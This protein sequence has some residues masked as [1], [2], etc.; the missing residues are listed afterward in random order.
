[1]K[2]SMKSIPLY[3]VFFISIAPATIIQVPQDQ[4][5]IQLG[6]DTAVHGDTV[7]V[8]TGTYVENI[9]FNGKNIL[10]GSLFLM[11]GD[12]SYISQTV[13]DGN[14]ITMVV[15]FESGEGSS[16]VLTGFTITNGGPG[17]AAGGIY[18]EASNP[19]I[20]NC[21]I[22]GNNAPDGGGIACVFNSNPTIINCTISGNSASAG[23]GIHCFDGSNP[24]IIN[25]ILWN[26][27]PQEIYFS[28]DSNPNTITIAYSN[29]QGGEASI[30]TNNNG[31][32]NWLEGN[33]DVD[34][35]F[36]DPE[37]GDFHLQEGSSCIDAGTQFFVW[38]GDILI[39]LSPHDYVGFARDM[40]A[41]EAPA[42]VI[43]PELSIFPT[44]G[45][46]LVLHEENPEA[47]VMFAIYNNGED[48]VSYNL[49]VES[50][51]STYILYT[52]E[53]DTTTFNGNIWM[54]R[55]DGTEKTQLTFEMLDRESVWSPD[56]EKI[57]FWS[58]RSGNADVWVMNADGSN[59]INLTDSEFG[60]W[61]PS[62]SSDG[63][64]IIFSSNRDVTVPEIYRMTSTGQD[65]QRLTFND[66]DDFRP[67]YSPNGQ[68]FVTHSRIPG[69][70]S[71][72]YVYMS[73]GQSFIN[74]GIPGLND[75]QPSWTPDGMRVVWSGILY[76]VNR[77][78]VSSL[79]DGSDLRLEYGT[80]QK[81]YYPRFSPDGYFLAF[82][83]STF[84][85]YGGDEIFVW[86]KSMNRLTQITDNTPV[87]REW[88]P[89]WSPFLNSP[90]WIT[91]DVDSSQISPGGSHSIT[92][93]INAS[94]VP[95]GEHT[96]SVMIIEATTGNL[97][98]AV[99]VNIR[100]TDT[101]GAEITEIVDV[102]D[103]QGGFVHIHFLRSFYDTD[104]LSRSQDTEFY[105]LWRRLED[106]S[107]EGLRSIGAYGQHRY[108]ILGE[109]FQDATDSFYQET[110]FRITAH[111]NEGNFD[112]ESAWG[113]S[114]DNIAPGIPGG[115]N[116]TTGMDFIEIS[117]E[118]SSDDDF[119]FFRI[120]R[121]MDPDFD[122]TE[123]ELMSETV[124][125]F[126]AEYGIESGEYFYVV[127]AVDYH[128]NESGFSEVVEATVS[129]VDGSQLPEEYSL[130][131]N[132]PNPF[133]PVTT[134]RYD[135]PERAEVVLTVYDILGREVKT[136]VRSVQEPGFKSV[137]WN[138]TND[139]G[140]PMSAGIYLYRIS[141]GSFGQ[142]GDFVQVKKM[143]LLK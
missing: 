115:F 6:I 37:N 41:F 40:G 114:W 9:N 52:D 73:D 132:Y 95:L 84:Y 36:V 8:D 85:P 33:I 57:V 123:A 48:T 49:H 11:T 63:E 28:D 143:V 50:S 60:E 81:E 91:V 66:W 22:I 12:T 46:T 105:T 39:N 38:E 20:T 4:P 82:P 43:G 65:I 103:D 74:I 15:T 62:W 59:P 94:N 133:N 2:N 32:I 29:V 18:C 26:N 117:W 86:H 35:L 124:E 111:M 76:G 141:A 23:G 79:W 58:Y 128:W 139:A 113:V 122:P 10:L 51:D 126:Y 121:V 17:G 19:T 67:R 130:S 16:A 92:L 101:Y 90:G 75:F 96:T 55:R 125:A 14:H 134:L 110:E 129:I 47:A 61:H 137:I 45:F 116:L 44:E 136:L 87:T 77:D 104:S 70:D 112:S 25:C 56:G 64:F 1:M 138:G 21:T 72:I 53:P 142:A 42:P 69:S 71:D 120:Y 135:L 140:R 97:L 7:L 108:T 31:T 89:D 98:V 3:V 68:Y 54:M 27:S 30:I 24:I 100:T 78:I 34:P 5:T 107:W 106:G 118:P 88:G 83:K 102:P 131:Q 13:I 93:T 127:T 119:Q 80:T 99:P 109:T